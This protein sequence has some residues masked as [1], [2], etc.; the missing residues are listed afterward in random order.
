MGDGEPFGPPLR[1]GEGEGVAPAPSVGDAVAAG[2]G[3]PTDTVA[4]GPR[5]GEIPSV[6][7]GSGEGDV[8]YDDR[9]TAGHCST[10]MSSVTADMTSRQISAG[11]E[12]PVTPSIGRFPS[13]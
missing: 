12:P 3:A 6:G 9:S 11:M 2:G 13:G 8:R 7:D 4:P 10:S 1:V 5:E